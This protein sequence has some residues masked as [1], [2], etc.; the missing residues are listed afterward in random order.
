MQGAG[1]VHVIFRLF[2]ELNNI[3]GTRFSI[4][5]FTNKNTKV[6][7]GE[8]AAIIGRQ[9]SLTGNKEQQGKANKSKK[10]KQKTNEQTSK[11]RNNVTKDTYVQSSIARKR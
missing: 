8:F 6:P 5:Q 1:G 10:K 2:Q 3:R 11:E 9:G 7:S 4:N